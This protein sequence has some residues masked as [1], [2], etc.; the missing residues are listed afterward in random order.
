MLRTFKYSL[1]W[2]SVVFFQTM[3]VLLGAVLLELVGFKLA[4]DHH[5]L[6]DLS[7]LS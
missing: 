2:G 1:F 4:A 3:V 6:A 7:D 5:D